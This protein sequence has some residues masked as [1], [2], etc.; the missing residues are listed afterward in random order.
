MHILTLSFDDGFVDSFGRI[1]DIYEKFGFSAC[2]NVIAIGHLIDPDSIDEWH[3]GIPKGDFKLWNELQARGHEIMPHGYRHANKSRLSFEEGKQ[4]IVKCLQVFSENLEGF[5]AE[6]A[7][8]NFPYN[9]STRELEAW[10]PDKV[11]AFRCGGAAIQPLPTRETVKISSSG[12]G[13]GNLEEHLDRCVQELLKTESG[14]L[15]YNT[16]G[17]DKEGW[18][19]IRA[20]YLEERLK[21]WTEIP[22]LR[23]LPSGKALATA[24]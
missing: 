7:V 16:H 9:A 24:N 15:V 17:L 1:A 13:P 18:G 14:W 20:S 19:P 3:A 21:E 5:R 12:A 4:L 2:L 23:I 10:L 8:F 6:N 11:R 22:S